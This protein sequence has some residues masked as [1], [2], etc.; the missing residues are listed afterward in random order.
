MAT[1]IVESNQGAGPRRAARV[2]VI[3]TDREVREHLHDRLEVF[4]I[5]VLGF[6][7]AEE[8]L[9]S[10]APGDLQ[11]IVTEVDL[12][13]IDGLQLQERLNAAHVSVPVLVLASHSDVP[14][15]VRAM[16]NG[17]VD[18]IEKPFVEEFLVSRIRQT[19]RKP[20]RLASPGE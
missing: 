12:P 4:G 11:C 7:T 16:Q 15:A 5:E 17:A 19:L 14:L 20:Q 18:F 13:G 3:D 10:F 2:Y 6:E 8:F 1:M 9:R